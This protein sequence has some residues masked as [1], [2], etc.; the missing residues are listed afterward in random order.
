MKEPIIRKTPYLGMEEGGGGGEVLTKKET[1]HLKTY[2][3]IFTIF[4]LSYK[5]VQVETCGASILI[6]GFEVVRRENREISSATLTS[7]T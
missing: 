6:P 7:S 4:S 3:I 1:S 5:V 2:F